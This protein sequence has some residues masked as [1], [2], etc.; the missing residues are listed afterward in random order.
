[1]AITLPPASLRNSSSSVTCR[2]GS[3]QG[4]LGLLESQLQKQRDCGDSL[5][6]P[7]QCHS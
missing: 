7:I 3:S 4:W 1:M 5:H 2:H 6:R